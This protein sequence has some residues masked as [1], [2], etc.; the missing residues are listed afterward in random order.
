MFN[1]WQSGKKYY[2]SLWG[3]ALLITFL[4][5]TMGFWNKKTSNGM[6]KQVEFSPDQA[7][8][9]LINELLLSSQNLQLEEKKDFINLYIL[10][11][12]DSNYEGALV[13]EN[14]RNAVYKNILSRKLNNLTKT[15]KPQADFSIKPVPR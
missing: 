3:G 13:I 1:S 5:I 9:E 15:K 12:S 11:R 8:G 4:V 2:L 7:A 14:K 10:L 6:L